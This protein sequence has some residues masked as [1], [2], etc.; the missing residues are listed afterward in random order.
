VYFGGPEQKE[1]TILYIWQMGCSEEFW[2]DKRVWVF[3][4]A[5]S[6]NFER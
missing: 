2:N 4:T 3:L 6:Q 5:M 1:I